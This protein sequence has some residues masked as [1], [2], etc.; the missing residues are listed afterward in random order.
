MNLQ[1]YAAKH[2]R[3]DL[4][5]GVEL[6]SDTYQERRERFE[7]VEHLKQDILQWLE[8]GGEPGII[9][10]AALQALSLATGDDDFAEKAS[11]FLIGEQWDLPLFVDLDELHRRRE[12]RR[13][14]YF[15]KRRRAA[16]RQLKLLEAD[17]EK[18]LQELERIPR[19]G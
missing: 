8:Q 14:E 3:K 7:T 11:P 1:E 16:T 2:G 15:E 9:L 4:P 19:E 13:K 17:R 6:P 12:E 10:Q 5:V 18:L